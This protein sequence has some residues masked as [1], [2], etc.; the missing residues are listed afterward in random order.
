MLVH[1][2][3]KSWNK[4][5]QNPYPACSYS[6]KCCGSII[7]SLIR[8]FSLLHLF[9]LFG[10]YPITC[11]LFSAFHQFSHLSL[12]KLSLEF[13]E[14]FVR[15]RRLHSFRSKN[16]RVVIMYADAVGF[17]ECLEAL[18]NFLP[19]PSV[20]FASVQSV[21]SSWFWGCDKNGMTKTSL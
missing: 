15:Y 3:S 11:K 18:L 14:I 20:K 4:A 13:R 6:C 8:S 19:F 9:Q 21:L 16:D 12:G 17:V 5:S 2:N 1:L 7:C 10:K